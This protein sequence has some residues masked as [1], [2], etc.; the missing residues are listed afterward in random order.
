MLPVLFKIGPITIYTYGLMAATGFI[1]ASLLLSR[2][3]RI[4]GE[5]PQLALDLAFYLVV[6]ALIGSRILYVIIEYRQYV[7]NPLGIFKIWEGG[8]VFYGGFIAAA[9]TGF[10]FVKK[11]NLHPWKFADLAAPPIAIGHAFGRVGCLGAGCCYG[12]VTDSPIGIVFTDPKALAP[13]NVP[14][15]PTQIFSSLNELFIFLILITVRPRKK[16]HGQ[17][18]LLWMMLYAVGRFIIEIYRGDPRGQIG[19]LSSSQAV[20]IAAFL[21]AGGLTIRLLRKASASKA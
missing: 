15:Y 13:L 10:W 19:P 5:D 9:L 12:K 16:F 3:A 2:R 14:L 20:A 4:E 8:L 21:I 7:H 17:L 1:V 18:F 11:H 6:A